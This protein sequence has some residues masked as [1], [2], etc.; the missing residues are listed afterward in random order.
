MLAVVFER[1]LAALRTSVGVHPAQTCPFRLQSFTARMPVRDRGW[2]RRTGGWNWFGMCDQG[3]A[4]RVGEHHAV[5]EVGVAADQQAT[6]VVELV[7]PR[8][9]G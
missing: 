7:M 1:L 6:K 2:R 4:R 5:G 3:S 8:A 9:S